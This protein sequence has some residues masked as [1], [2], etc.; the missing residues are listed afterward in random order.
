LAAVSW[1]GAVT[2]RSDQDYGVSSQCAAR[3][4]DVDFADTSNR[5]GQRSHNINIQNRQPWAP[6]PGSIMGVV[7]DLTGK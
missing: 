4:V 7:S 3:E 6:A 2:V 1:L 5:K